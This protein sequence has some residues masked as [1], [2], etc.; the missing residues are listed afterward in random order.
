MVKDQIS[1]HDGMFDGNRDHYF[2]FAV[3][4][5]ARQ[6]IEVSMFAAGIETFT[7]ILDLPCHY[8]HIQLVNYTEK[9]V[10]QSSGRCRFFT[11]VV[12]KAGA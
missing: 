9:G 5:S 4:R 10:G 12:P 7:N 3:G 11:N 8:G 6:C 2:A 1:E